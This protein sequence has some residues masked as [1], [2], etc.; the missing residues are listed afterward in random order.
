MKAILKQIMILWNIYSNLQWR[1]RWQKI[2]GNFPK[3]II[4]FLQKFVGNPK[5]VLKQVSKLKKDF[6]KGII[7]HQILTPHSKLYQPN[8]A[9]LIK[10]YLRLQLR[11]KCCHNFVSIINTIT[12]VFLQSCF[13]NLGQKLMPI[14]LALELRR[15]LRLI[16]S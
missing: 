10:I 15:Q 16:R 14:F 3:N 2:K 12:I 11:W 8:S 1:A 9:Y 6:H 5:M 13:H 4:W 7:F